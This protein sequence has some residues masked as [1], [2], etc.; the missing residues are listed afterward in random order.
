MLIIVFWMDI[1]SYY[2]HLRAGPEL[3]FEDLSLTEKVSENIEKMTKPRQ[4]SSIW[5]ITSHVYA[6][7]VSYIL[8]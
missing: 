8:I 5:I 4:N 1:D 2:L 7:W 3:G 6:D